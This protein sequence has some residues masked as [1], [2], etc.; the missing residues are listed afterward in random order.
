[1]LTIEYIIL[2]L[3]YTSLI[4]S[5]IF[6]WLCYKKKMENL[7]TITFTTSILLLVI[8]ISLSPILSKENTTNIYTLLCMILIAATTFLQT[9]K[10]QKHNIPKIYKKVHIGISIALT[11][12]VILCNTLDYMKFSQFI[13]VAFLI[14]SIVF[15]MVVTQQ[16]KPLRQFLHNEKSNKIFAIVFLILVPIYLITHYFFE[17]EFGQFQIGFLLYFALIALVVR[18]IYDDLQRLSLIKSKLN[19]KDQQLEN[20]GLTQREQEV[21]KLLLE[22]LTYQDI[23]SKLFISLPTV[24]THTSKIYKKCKVKNRNELSHLLTD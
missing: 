23:T 20:Y 21:A 7:E 18:K 13:V 17:N 15:S 8:S 12:F 5:L 10:E 19:P 2:I 6:Q 22:G 14:I 4:I 16:T 9:L 24:K 11:L 3:L 1:M